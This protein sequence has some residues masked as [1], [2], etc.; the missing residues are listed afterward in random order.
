M[1]IDEAIIFADQACEKQHRAVGSLL[2]GDDLETFQSWKQRM[3]LSDEELGAVL[4]ETEL[5]GCYHDPRLSA[6]EVDSV[7]FATDL[8]MAGVVRFLHSPRV[9]LGAFFVTKKSGQLRMILDA[10]RSNR[11]FRRPPSTVLGTAE[12]WPRL[13][14]PAGECMFVAQEDIRDFFYRLGIDAELSRY[15]SLPGVDA[16]LLKE[17][18]LEAGGFPQTR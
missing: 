11:L 6:S 3:L 17:S 8:F 2:E 1:L 18:I 5:S 15:F 14:I 12:C 16:Q 4:Q 10:R 7:H 13:V 9:V